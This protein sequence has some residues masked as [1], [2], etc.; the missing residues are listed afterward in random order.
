MEPCQATTPVPATSLKKTRTT[1]STSG[2]PRARQGRLW[3]SRTPRSVRRV[4]LVRFYRAKAAR[5]LR[6]VYHVERGPSRRLRV[7][8]SASRVRPARSPKP[9]AP[10]RATGAPLVCS[11]TS[12]DQ[13]PLWG[14][15]AVPL[16]H[17]ATLPGRGTA[18]RVLPGRSPTC[19]PRRSASRARLEPSCL[20]ETPR[21]WISAS[22]VR[23][24]RSPLKPALGS[25]YNV[26]T[27]PSRKV[28]GR[29]FARR[30][31]LVRRTARREGTRRT[32]AYL[33]QSEQSHPIQECKRVF[34][35]QRATS[36]RNKANVSASRAR[37][38]PTSQTKARARW[39]T[40]CPV[41]PRRSERTP[42]SRAR[43]GAM[44][45]PLGR[46][47]N[48][49]A[50]SSASRRRKGRFWTRPARTPVRCQSRAR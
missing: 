24:V 13:S 45:A 7:W 20:R 39:K 25:V 32:C 49:P 10:F 29:E 36:C 5:T 48:A 14:A 35:V 27:E 17:I 40:A 37:P 22:R 19:S 11:T 30:A 21:A 15:R 1:R 3:R 33:V 41:Q 47:A 38:V 2:A 26:P 34:P 18:R 6:I 4:R 16:V 12:S 8:T 28:K 46:L 50:R 9:K 23:L 31:L 44:R 42:R 43:R